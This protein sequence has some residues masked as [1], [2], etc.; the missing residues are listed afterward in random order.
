MEGPQGRKRDIL[1]KSAPTHLR[2]CKR[3]EIRAEDQ[4]KELGRGQSDIETQR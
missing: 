1:P 4:L 2:A 3:D